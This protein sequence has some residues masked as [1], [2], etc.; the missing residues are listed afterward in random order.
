MVENL[1]SKSLI[2]KMKESAIKNKEL[3][4][5]IKREEKL[6]DD[7][8]YEMSK[9]VKTKLALGLDIFRIQLPD[10]SFDIRKIIFFILNKIQRKQSDNIVLRQYLVSYPEFIDTLKLRE[11]IS[12]PKELL[13]KISQHLKKEEVFQDK[14]I[15]YNGQLGKTFYLILEG[16][17][18]VLLPYEYR[19]K[20]TDKQLF[21]YMNFLLKHKEHELIRLILESNNIVLNDDDYGENELYIKFKSVVDKALPAH[22]ETEKI[23]SQDYI[24]R[25]NFFVDLEN[26]TL[27]HKI[28]K[29]KEEKKEDIKKEE[30][31]E[32][33]EK[34]E[35]KEESKEIEE[36][37]DY[38]NDIKNLKN[39]F[40]KK[41]V[42]NN[43]SKSKDKRK[44][45]DKEND[46]EDNEENNMEKN[47]KK[48]FFYNIETIFTVWKYF[49]VCRLT[50]GKCFGELALQKDGKKRNATIITTQNSIFGI[51]QKDVYQMFIKETM[52][53]AR[54]L[55][56]E[57]LLKSKLFKGCNSEKFEAHY[58]NCFKFMKKYKGEYLFKQGEQRS[59]IYFIKKGEVQI[60]LFSTCFNIDNIVQNLGYP[61]ENIELKELIKSQK[62]LEQ[63]CS[64]NRKFNVLIFSG[65]AIG[66]NDHIIS[67]T[68]EELVF[69]GLC[70]TYCELF[71]LDN[72]FFNKI[73]DDKIIRNNFTK[74]V[75]E[76]K[77]RLAERLLQLRSNI[78][79][80]HY[81]FIK[82]NSINLN[83]NF[84]N[85][86]NEN[87][88]NIINKK[89]EYRKFLSQDMKI[90]MGTSNINIINNNDDKVLISRKKFDI[91]FN[92][93]AASFFGNYNISNNQNNN[94]NIIIQSEKNDKMKNFFNTENNF[95]KSKTIL[96]YKTKVNKR[97]SIKVLNVQ[98]L[99]SRNVKLKTKEDNLISND[100]N[101]INI[102]I[103]NKDIKK[104][105][106]T[107]SNSFF[108]N[109]NHGTTLISPRYS[110]MNS[111]NSKK[112]KI[113]KIKK[114]YEKTNKFGRK[115]KSY[116]I[117]NFEDTKNF[118]NFGNIKLQKLLLKQSIVYNT[119]I[120]KI[121]KIII[122]NYE[123][124]TPLSCKISINKEKEKEKDKMSNII[125][126]EP[127]FDIEKIHQRKKKYCYLKDKI[128]YKNILNE[129]KC[130]KRNNFSLPKLN[131][132]N[133]IKTDNQI[134][135]QRE[136]LNYFNNKK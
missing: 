33:K 136:I 95:N 56:V 101:N 115:K 1:S 112:N 21:K 42:N 24:K 2:R 94:N 59:L 81:N 18:S 82:E 84:R 60:E 58:F 86:N 23:S 129:N 92:K 22:L 20:I 67:D 87:D 12:D 121:D 104:K 35:E 36:S 6:L 10:S 131:K 106:S 76:R 105:I 130:Y 71:A 78:I 110:E 133:Y 48:N 62:K 64:V 109:N 125:N 99:I 34:K 13:L 40:M 9:Y 7:E 70:A 65:D 116:S 52:D 51:V 8:I 119:E 132:N 96:S 128:K 39:K 44:N 102:K 27:F 43:K 26:K 93:T 17:V 127:N 15:F 68:N 29:I 118:I 107:F 88:G 4:S 91:N 124:I 46:K 11:Q 113:N 134:S 63:F 135:S 54:K 126:K 31:K 123:K 120:D 73:L 111:K 85:N 5:R 69:S 75:K 32:E 14:V 79:I 38:K 16:E 80:Q 74:M 55:N 47:K 114:Q 49:E 25:Y 72:K 98:E 53:K 19:I 50:K 45:E 37:K 89:K 90:D 30:E 3:E 83:K 57:L 77:E 97:N 66:L 122:N 108:K 117:N 100:N 41:V 61:D 103:Q 28:K